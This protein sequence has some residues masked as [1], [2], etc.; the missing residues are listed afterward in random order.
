MLLSTQRNMKAMILKKV[1]S[2]FLFLYYNYDNYICPFF[3]LCL[4]LH[5][6][7]GRNMIKPVT[8]NSAGFSSETVY[9]HQTQSQITP[10]LS[11]QACTTK[12]ITSTSLT[13]PFTS[14]IYTMSSSTITYNSIYSC[15]LPKASTKIHSSNINVSEDIPTAPPAK[16]EK[17]NG[18]KN[19]RGCSYLRCKLKKV[20]KTSV[21]V[22]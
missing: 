17:N 16:I 10:P 7:L 12:P 13:K 20:I 4:I 18:D 8:L 15:V 5:F 9:L 22:K 2:V 1:Y 6:I 11:P 14:P 3:A 21:K 19:C